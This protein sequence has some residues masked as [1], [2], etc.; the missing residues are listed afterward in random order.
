ADCEQARTE[1]GGGVWAIEDAIRGDGKVGW[2]IKPQ[3]H[4]LHTA[5]FRLSRALRRAE[6]APG[7]RLRVVL[8]QDYGGKHTIGRFRLAA[9]GDE[10]PLGARPISQE[11]AGILTVAGEQRTSQQREQVA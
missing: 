8:G 3:E 5:A 10:E 2:A 1:T 7:L 11:I 9:T 4:R 6:G